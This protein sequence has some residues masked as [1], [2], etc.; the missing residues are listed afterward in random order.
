MPMTWLTH[1]LIPA[2][3][4][5]LAGLALINFDRLNRDNIEHIRRIHGADS[6]LYLWYSRTCGSAHFALANKVIFTLILVGCVGWII[7][8]LVAGWRP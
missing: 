2:A 5:I 8:S 1:Y 6:P 4:A 7:F 3:V